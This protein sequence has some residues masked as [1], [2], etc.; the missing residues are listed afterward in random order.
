MPVRQ[1]LHTASLQDADTICIQPPPPPEPSAPPIGGDMLGRGE[2]DPIDNHCL[3]NVRVLG[4]LKVD[5]P[6]GRIGKDLGRAGA[7]TAPAC[8]LH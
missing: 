2:S 4:F 5:L 6:S 3:V 8:R 1:F 7:G